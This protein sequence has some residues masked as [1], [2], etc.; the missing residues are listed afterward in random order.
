M[1]PYLHERYRYFSG[2]ILTTLFQHHYFNRENGIFY[3][4]DVLCRRSSWNSL[5]NIATTLGKFEESGYLLCTLYLLVISDLQPSGPTV[6]IH[7][8]PAGQ[9]RNGIVFG[10][11][12]RAA[13]SSS[14]N[15]LRLVLAFYSTEIA[16]HVRNVLIQIDRREKLND[17]LQ[18][19][20]NEQHARLQHPP[21]QH[22]DVYISTK[23]RRAAERNYF[24]WISLVHRRRRE[25]GGREAHRSVPSDWLLSSGIDYIL[26]FC[27]IR[28]S[29]VHH[30]SV[31]YS[32][33]NCHT[34]H[35][36]DMRGFVVCADSRGTALHVNRFS[37][38]IYIIYIYMHIHLFT[39]IIT[40]ITQLIVN[41][42]NQVF[43][44]Y[45]INC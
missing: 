31:Y 30:F 40:Y 10:G 22:A 44:I 4:R 35:V 29:H 7:T 16:L 27:N 37:C 43:F 9:I 12:Q 25:I 11:R 19:N 34:L 33:A 26:N 13:A 21:R 45:L 39:V 28:A 3:I 8:Y 5:R 20:E 2:V 24:N 41:R 38:I 15:R 23:T 32:A 42:A 17:K 14:R 18:Q 6:Y 36:W 1:R